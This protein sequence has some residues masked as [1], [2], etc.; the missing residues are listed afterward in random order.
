MPPDFFH[1]VLGHTVKL[2]KQAFAP[3]KREIM[4]LHPFFKQAVQYPASLSLAKG[5][6]QWGE[7]GNDDL[8]DCTVAAIAHMIEVWDMWA[9]KDT[10]V[11]LN[12]QAVI[13]F[14]EGSGYVPGQSNTDQGWTVSDA[15]AQ[16]KK[17]GLAGERAL[18]D[19][20]L[21]LGYG[22]GQVGRY[23]IQACLNIFQGVDL[24]AMLPI[25]AQAQTGSGIWDVTTGYPN[26]PNSQ[27]GSW[28]GHS[29]DLVSYGLLGVTGLTWG[30][31]Q[32]MT[33][34]FLDAYVDE[35][36]GVVPSEFKENPNFNLQSYLKQLAQLTS[37]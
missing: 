32:R 12:D 18:G 36:W 34:A 3:P 29:Y 14:Y 13:K 31:P 27:P 20:L 6:L 16:F 5:R 24:G 28:G 22:E 30:V 35:P 1:P 26:D 33:W 17:S 37:V 21:S 7:F 19:G 2:G 8:S 10:T 4:M 9:P 15:L 25:T 23:D 11:G